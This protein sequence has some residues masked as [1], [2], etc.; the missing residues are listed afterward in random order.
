MLLKNRQ[1]SQRLFT[2]L[3][4]YPKT[5]LLCCL[6]AAATVILKIMS[7]FLLIQL[8]DDGILANHSVIP[9]EPFIPYVLVFFGIALSGALQYYFN[10]ELAFFSLRD[11]RQQLFHHTLDLR[12][13]DREKLHKGEILARVMV[14]TETVHGLISSSL[15][16]LFFDLLFLVGVLLFLL[17]VD[18]RLT[19]LTI[20][21]LILLILCISQSQ[22]KVSSVFSVFLQQ[23]GKSLS[24]AREQFQGLATLHDLEIKDIGDQRYEALSAAEL[25]ENNDAVW[26]CNLAST[27]SSAHFLWCLS[28]LVAVSL[29]FELS[30]GTSLALF[31][32]F[33]L[34]HRVL[35]DLTTRF[36]LLSKGMAALDRVFQ[37]VP[38]ENK[39]ARPSHAPALGPLRHSLRFHNV[40]FSYDQIPVLH[41]VD[42]EIRP[43]ETVGLVGLSGAGK[44]TLFKLIEGSRSPSE[45]QVYWDHKDLEEFDKES[46]PNRVASL[47]QFR[48]ELDQLF[49]DEALPTMEDYLKHLLTRQPDLLVLDE[50]PLEQGLF[51]NSDLKLFQ[52]IKNQTTL[53]SSHQ[54]SLVKQCD[55][56]L[57]LEEGRITAEGSH[58]ELVIGNDFYRSLCQLQWG[59]I[60]DEN[61]SVAC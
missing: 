14:D 25:K 44:S 52:L 24:F 38:E 26:W 17:I 6:F 4:S 21:T 51:E 30:A 11:L 1:N 58:D 54:V 18:W 47:P 32:G 19:L 28:I 3:S 33:Y 5:L 9:W 50:Y 45:G 36:T 41:G 43:G 20:P 23:R 13:A 8:I 39:A 49:A 48:T 61:V 22:K 56:I 16:G 59:A 2:L 60:A 46:V 27:L 10:N 40:S 12:S 15:F 55:R 57:V 31:Q 35:E 34:L 37:F 7:P 42:F 53:I 29:I